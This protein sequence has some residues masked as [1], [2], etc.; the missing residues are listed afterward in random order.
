MKVSF[1]G[2]FICFLCLM[3]ISC[4][5]DSTDYND[6]PVAERTTGDTY[7]GL[8]SPVV[9]NP[10]ETSHVT[11]WSCIYFGEYPTAEIVDGPFSSVDDYALSEGDVME[12]AVL[13]DKLTKAEWTGDDTEIE[14]KRY[15]RICG[16]GAVTCSANREQHYRWQDASQWKYFEYSPIKWRIL[17]ITGT[18]ALLLADRMPDTCPFHDKAE[19][20]SWSESLL[21][22]WLNSEFYD[23][24]FQTAEKEAIVLTDVVNAPNYYFGTSCGPDTKDHVFI[25]SESEV[26]S[27]SLAEDYGFY[28]G[29]GTDDSARRFKATLYAKCRGAWWSPVEGYRGNSFWFMRSSGYTRTNVTY[30]CDFGYLYNRGTVVTCD[31][32]AVLPAVTIDLSKAHYQE[33]APVYSTEINN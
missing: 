32:A 6:N 30:V 2:L 1:N 27:S 4:S 25:L 23:K 14:G 17:N 13:Y 5:K 26:F 11:K 18:K 28:P 16:Q 21:R 9:R 33:A 20:V 12:D 15:R 10:K 7:K 29:D 31:D 22:G 24:A 8:S 19:D 3:Y